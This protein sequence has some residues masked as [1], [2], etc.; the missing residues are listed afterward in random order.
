MQRQTIFRGLLV[1][2]FVLSLLAISTQVGRTIFSAPTS[3]DSI[4]ITGTSGSAG[5][6][7]R[8]R[9]RA[10][11]TVPALDQ[12]VATVKNDKTG[13]VTGVYVQ[14]VLALRVVQQP[15]DLA[16]YVS[17]A[18]NAATQ[19]H[20]AANYGTIGLLA[21][22]YLAGQLFDG[23]TVGQ[24]VSVVYGDGTVRAYAVNGIRHLQA[25]SPLDPYSSFVDYENG[26]RQLSSTELFN[27]IYAP[28]NRVVF[29][30]CITRDGN[31]NWGRLF[32]IATPI[33]AQ[34]GR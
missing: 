19:F 8:V 7:A 34:T 10:L 12:F 25:L 33:T 9:A 31:M 24:T 5:A 4:T 26:N 22:N 13:V 15:G 14:D 6:G 11:D 16:I 30:T 17:L 20:L 29:Q 3:S 1:V 2:G 32:V 27:Q 18:Q 28:G 21:H 23:L